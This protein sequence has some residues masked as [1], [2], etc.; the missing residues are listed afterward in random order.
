MRQHSTAHN[1]WGKTYDNYVL[2]KFDIFSKCVVY[3]FLQHHISPHCDSLFW[4]HKAGNGV[5]IFYNC[6][7]MSP[8]VG[9]SGSLLHDSHSS[10]CRSFWVCSKQHLSAE[11]NSSWS[12]CGFSL[13]V[14]HW[15]SLWYWEWS[16]TPAHLPC[17]SP[18]YWGPPAWETSCH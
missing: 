12:W 13:S 2:I 4:C 8:L 1:M 18:G 3:N 10:E 16:H 11:A 14:L 6:Y 15:T 9:K 7:K 17:L 5:E